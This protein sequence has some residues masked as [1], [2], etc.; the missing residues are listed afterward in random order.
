MDVFL[1]PFM[2]NLYHILALF[3][4]IKRSK[5]YCFEI[6]IK[7]VLL[8][9]KFDVENFQKSTYRFDLI[10]SYLSNDIFKLKSPKVSEKSSNGANILRLT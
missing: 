4:V 8:G 9:K 3:V 6:C 1:Q 5:L 7:C 10:S 2:I